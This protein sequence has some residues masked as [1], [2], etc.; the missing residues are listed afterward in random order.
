MPGTELAGEGRESARVCNVAGV[1]LRFAAGHA[2]AADAA[3]DGSALERS[4]L[5]PAVSIPEHLLIPHCFPCL[6]LPSA[7]LIIVHSN[8]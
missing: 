7:I 6:A 1:S 5:G 2:D 3:P 8:S 4:W